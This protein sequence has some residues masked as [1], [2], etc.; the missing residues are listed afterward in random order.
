MSVTCEFENTPTLV[1]ISFYL[2]SF[3]QGRHQ[4]YWKFNCCITIFWS[5]LSH[6]SWNLYYIKLERLNLVHMLRSYR[7]KFL[8]GV[9]VDFSLFTECKAFQISSLTA[10]KLSER[11]NLKSMFSIL[12]ALGVNVRYSNKSIEYTGWRQRKNCFTSVSNLTFGV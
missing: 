7:Y 1:S 10:S 2:A 9:F 4:N 11:P 6:N 5:N 3:C 12:V 8:S